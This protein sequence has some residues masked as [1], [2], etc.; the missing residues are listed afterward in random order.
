MSLTRFLVRLLS[1]S[2]APVPSLV[3]RGWWPSLPVYLCSLWSAATLTN[4]SSPPAKI[5]R[6]A[7]CVCSRTVIVC[8]PAN[9]PIP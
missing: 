8:N 7:S 2:Q 6:T 9:L 5:S 4:S 3:S 1:R